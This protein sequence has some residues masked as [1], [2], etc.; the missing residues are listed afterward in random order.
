MMTKKNINEKERKHT[1]EDV[2][3]LKLGAMNSQLL[4]FD[5]SVEENCK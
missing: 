1:D 5:E 4:W 3:A 2:K